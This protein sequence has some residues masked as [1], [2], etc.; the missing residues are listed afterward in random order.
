MIREYRYMWC[1]FLKE[2][3]E[4]AKP[5]SLFPKKKYKRAYPMYNPFNRE[6]EE[7]YR[8][9]KHYTNDQWIR[10]FDFRSLLR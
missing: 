2:L 9:Y 8:A 3:R 6:R 4:S 1:F 10:G 5:D 7:V